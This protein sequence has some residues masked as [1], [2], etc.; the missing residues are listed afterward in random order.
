MPSNLT[1]EELALIGPLLPVHSGLGSH[2][3]WAYRQIVNG[4]FYVLRAGLP[5]RMLP[6]STFPAMTI[7][8]NYFHA[9]RG[10]GLWITLD[11]HLLMEVREAHGRRH[12]PSQT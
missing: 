11:Q 9:W 12:Y 3:K 6:R 1:D 7:V 2:V 10:S 8:Q 4:L 5:W